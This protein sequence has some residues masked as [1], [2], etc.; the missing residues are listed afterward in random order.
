MVD[1][2]YKMPE[3]P[4]DGESRYTF[5]TPLGDLT[6]AQKAGKIARMRW[7]K[8]PSEAEGATTDDPLFQAAESQVREYF[9]EKREVFDLPLAPEGTE[10]Q[11][12]VWRALYRIP[13]GI[14]KTYG[15]IADEV[16][17]HARAVGIACGANP[18]P[19]VIPCHRVMGANGKMTGF[20]AYGGIEDKVALLQIES[21]VLL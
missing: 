19:L 18:I 11:K 1:D 4:D 20:S 8:G 12:A 16:G 5:P 3:H 14:T 10:F 15:D 9:A 21:G 2:S 6:V 13:F 7:K 17:G